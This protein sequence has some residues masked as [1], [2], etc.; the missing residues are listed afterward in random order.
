VAAS[1]VLGNVNGSFFEKI[2]HLTMNNIRQMWATG[3]DQFLDDLG[4]EW[5]CLAKWNR[6]NTAR[7]TRKVTDW[8]WRQWVATGIWEGWESGLVEIKDRKRSKGPEN[9]SGWR[10]FQT[11]MTVRRRFD[12]SKSYENGFK[13]SIPV[14]TCWQ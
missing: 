10:L 8:W 13:W 11:F 4:W 9:R 7:N 14:K 5:G 12:P 6:V 2:G 1:A 3:W